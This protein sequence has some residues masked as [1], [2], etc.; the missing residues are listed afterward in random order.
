M[1]RCTDGS[2]Q[3]IENGQCANNLHTP[4]PPAILWPKFCLKNGRATAFHG[5]VAHYQQH[6]TTENFSKRRNIW[7]MATALCILV[8]LCFA[9]CCAGKTEHHL[10]VGEDM[11]TWLKSPEKWVRYFIVLSILQYCFSVLVSVVSV[12]YDCAFKNGIK[13]NFSPF[14]C[15]L[16]ATK[17]T[18]FR[19]PALQTHDLQIWKQNPVPTTQRRGQ[20]GEEPPRPGPP[21]GSAASGRLQDVLLEILDFLLT[22]ISFWIFN[23]S[24]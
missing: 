13:C 24:Y 10:K 12:S 20:P 22:L 11:L 21:E 8:L 9:S 6:L 16:G 2:K 3:K 17:K 14:N 4:P 5:E 18:E 23:A 1:L 15:T 7:R 19:R